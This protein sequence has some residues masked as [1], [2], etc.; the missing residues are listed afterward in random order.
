MQNFTQRVI[1]IIQRIP[2]GKV[3]TY[4]RIG[5]M[6]GHPNGARQVARILHSSSRTRKLAWHRVVNVQ[7]R[8]SLPE[9][10]GY[11]HQKA[12]L[13]AEGVV[14]DDTDRIDMNRFLW[15]GTAA[16]SGQQVRRD[17]R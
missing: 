14:F 10:G 17:R 9:N 2:E 1:K 15:D 4:G 3:C 11:E 12:R 13:Q 8:I 6:A 16:R 7:G 5:R